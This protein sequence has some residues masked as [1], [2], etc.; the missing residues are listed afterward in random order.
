M[1]TLVSC[2][3]IEQIRSNTLV[4]FRSASGPSDGQFSVGV[5][6][7]YWPES[8]S[9]GQQIQRLKTALEAVRSPTRG[10][11]FVVQTQPTP[12]TS[13]I[14]RGLTGTAPGGL[15]AFTGV[16]QAGMQAFLDDPQWFR[17]LSGLVFIEDFSNG[18]D[19]TQRAMRM[20]GSG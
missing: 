14:L 20:M 8:S 15:L 12:D 18:I 16:Y 5:N 17:G 19:L 7:S 3:K 10:Y 2:S 1:I 9:E 11:L 13:T 6:S 4:S